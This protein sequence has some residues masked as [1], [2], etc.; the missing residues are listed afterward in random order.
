MGDLV[1]H[2]LGQLDGD[3]ADD[4]PLL[5]V[6]ARGVLGELGQEVEEGH[7]VERVGGA[8]DDGLVEHLDQALAV[9]PQRL[10]R[11]VQV[12]LLLDLVHVARVQADDPAPVDEL[13]DGGR[14]DRGRRHRE[15]GLHASPVETERVKVVLGAYK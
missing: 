9:V 10:E 1:E 2:V 11:G 15:S 4:L 13:L 3:G 8:I 5:G 12:D 14:V 7:A 6:P